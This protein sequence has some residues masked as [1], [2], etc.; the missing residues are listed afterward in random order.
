MTGPYSRNHPSAKI[1]GSKMIQSANL[2]D[3]DATETSDVVR[4]GTIMFHMN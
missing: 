3:S 1:G 2:A 4:I